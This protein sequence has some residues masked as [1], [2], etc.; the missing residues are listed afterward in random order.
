MVASSTCAVADGQISSVRKICVSNPFAK[1]ILIFRNR[2][3]VY[4]RGRPAL[5]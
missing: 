5:T 3:S 2:D 4:I 1:N